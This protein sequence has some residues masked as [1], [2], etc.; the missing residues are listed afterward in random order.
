MAFTEKHEDA[1]AHIRLKPFSGRLQ[2]A[3]GT[4]VCKA[5]EAGQAPVPSTLPQLPPAL[6]GKPSIGQV[7][8]PL[9]C[10]PACLLLLCHAVLLPAAVPRWDV[11]VC[12]HHH[13]H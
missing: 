12:C 1:V 5:D 8:L 10:C 13:V 4:G 11:C 6:Q 7:C 9:L 2:A 3:G